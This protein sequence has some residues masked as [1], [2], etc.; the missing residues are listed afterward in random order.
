MSV[1]QSQHKDSYQTNLELYKEAG[2]DI[3]GILQ[4]CLE[5]PSWSI[6]QE[7]GWK[8]WRRNKIELYG[9]DALL[10]VFPEEVSGYHSP[11]K[12]S[13]D[14]L[15]KMGITTKEQ[16]LFVDFDTIKTRVKIDKDDR[17]L[18]KVIQNFV[19]CEFHLKWSNPLHK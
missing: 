1:E 13:L 12:Y 8:R 19:L 11:L 15:E 4:K 10:A 3:A 14:S 17:N 18:Y 7:S 6:Q 5:V 9:E 2:R 16:I